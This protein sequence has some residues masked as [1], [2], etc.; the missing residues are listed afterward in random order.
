MGRSDGILL[1]KLEE[2]EEKFE[3]KE[4]DRDF[5]K[6]SVEKAG[7]V[8][9]EDWVGRESSVRAGELKVAFEKRFGGKSDREDISG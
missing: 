9:E 2:Y 8:V 5:I 1:E 6:V 7:G 4:P 3:W